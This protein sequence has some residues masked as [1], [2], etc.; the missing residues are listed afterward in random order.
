MKQHESPL[1]SRR[2]VLAASAA[3]LA[4]ASL[5]SRLHARNSRETI[6][7]GLIGCGGRGVGAVHNALEADANTVVTAV[8]D[9]FVSTRLDGARGRSYGALPPGT[10]FDTIIARAMPDAPAA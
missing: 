6:R 8:A 9:A 1:P 3:T 4:T 7:I 2:A 10:D 5:G